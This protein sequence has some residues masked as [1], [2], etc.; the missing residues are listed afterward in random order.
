MEIEMQSINSYPN[1]KKIFFENKNLSPEDIFEK[2]KN[3]EMTQKEKNAFRL[4]AVYKVEGN[5]SDDYIK[6]VNYVE[7]IT[8]T[9][10]NIDGGKSLRKRKVTRKSGKSKK[11]KYTRR[12]K[13]QNIRRK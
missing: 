6:F 10:T 4:L 8:N 2:I 3:K 5:P 7:N 12:N 9:E 11:H 13:K 1:L